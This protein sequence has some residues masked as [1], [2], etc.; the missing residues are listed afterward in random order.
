VACRGVL[1]SKGLTG[2]DEHQVRRSTSWHRWVTLAM[3]AHAFVTV[4]TAAERDATPTPDGLIP[5]TVNEQRRLID[6]L[7]LR[8]HRALDRLRHWSTWRRRHQA[9]ARFRH[10]RRRDQPP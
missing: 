8:P 4:I 10:Y 5:I 6:A 2:L 1:T 9:R 7:I 3:L